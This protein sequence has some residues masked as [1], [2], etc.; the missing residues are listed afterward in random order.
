[1]KA[2]IKSSVSR[3]IG[4][5]TSLLLWLTLSENVFAQTATGSAGKGGTSGALPNAGSTDLTYVLFIGGLVL[6]VVGTLKLA[7][8]FKD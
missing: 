5:S 1:M 4:F 8:S 7:L 3:F 6:F 2:C